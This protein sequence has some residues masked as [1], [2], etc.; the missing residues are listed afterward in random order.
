MRTLTKLLLCLLLGLAA[1]L[2]A[3]AQEGEPPDGTRV[4]TAEV[5]GIDTGDLSPGLRRDIDALAGKP[6]ARSDVT[7]LARRIEE[8]RPEV[9]VAVRVVG[10][11]GDEARV[12]FLVARISDDAN[13]G[14]NINARYTVE[15]VELDG[16]KEQEISADLRDRLQALVGT[17]LD[18][19]ATDAL[20][21]ALEAEKP[22]YDVSRRIE[23]GTRRG[24]IRVV[25]RFSESERLRWI[26][27]TRSRSKYVYHS[28]QG[29]SGVHDI[30]MGGRD[31]R[32]TVGF[33]IDD[34]DTLVEEYSGVRVRFES[35]RIGTER[36]AASLEASWLN[37]HWRAP[38]LAAL[39]A[40]PLAPDPYRR[41]ITVEPTL[42]VALTRRLRASGGVSFSSLESLHRSPDT[43]M[44]SAVTGGLVYS[45]RWDRDRRTR[46][47]VEVGYS[48]RASAG[49]LG[50]DVSFKRH[51]GRARYALDS[52]HNSFIFEVIGGGITGD[53]PLFER[54][55]LGDST[56]LRGWNKF[57]VAPIGGNRVF[58]QSLE[59][60]F[61]GAALFLDAG[62]VWTQGG[63]RELRTSTGFG[64]HVDH[65]FA[66]VAF[67]LNAA[68]SGAT[69][70]MGVRF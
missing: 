31:H 41:R 35:R 28:E 8:E 24:Q 14:S 7:Q 40:D 53:A 11:P 69:F 32:V 39:D 52:R 62:S 4:A 65:F 45:Q 44:A 30:P 25:F 19:D 43:Q 3:A 47:D 16:L 9:I 1:P 66:T 64:F 42:T 36:V 63:E 60:R 61:H 67:P 68:N 13:L 54:F 33:A 49:G 51:L 23:R 57:E 12:V 70:M 55:T 18:G 29:W 46:Q 37:S 56:T 17:R 20:I 2:P 10:A 38:T 15:S 48:L 27:F 26:P 50:G 34:N 59:Y 5:S 6:L 21:K 58:H 22:G